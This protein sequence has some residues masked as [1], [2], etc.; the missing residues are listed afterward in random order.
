M[1]GRVG[2]QVCTMCAS[3][4]HSHASQW[5]STCCFVADCKALLV[6]G[7]STHLLITT[8]WGGL[9]VVCLRMPELASRGTLGNQPPAPWSRSPA[10]PTLSLAS[11]VASSLL[12]PLLL[13]LCCSAIEEASNVS[14]AC[15]HASELFRMQH[16]VEQ[17][18]VRF[19]RS[20]QLSSYAVR[21]WSNRLQVLSLRCYRLGIVEAQTVVAEADRWQSPLRAVK[22]WRSA[23]SAV[24]S[25]LHAQAFNSERTG[26]SARC[27]PWS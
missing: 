18:M 1:R 7:R 13:L 20:T 10:V 8:V 15:V 16:P 12:L 22:P 4:P 3:A 21:S 27:T 2:T 5:P 24:C 25:M 6:S 11:L 23:K 19:D 9:A 26:E 17:R 14:F